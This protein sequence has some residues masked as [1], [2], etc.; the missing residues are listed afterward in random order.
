MCQLIESMDRSPRAFRP[1]VKSAD[2]PPDASLVLRSY[3]C[4][5]G[6]EERAAAWVRSVY[7]GRSDVA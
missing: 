1:A 6:E 7:G 5:S 4:A 2:E 3:P